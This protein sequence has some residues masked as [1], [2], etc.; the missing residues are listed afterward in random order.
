[1]VKQA[2]PRK[3][4]RPVLHSQLRFSLSDAGLLLPL[5]H[6]GARRRS[7]ALQRHAHFRGEKPSIKCRARLKTGGVPQWAAPEPSLRIDSQGTLVG[8]DEPTAKKN[9]CVCWISL[10][11]G[12][13]CTAETTSQKFFRPHYLLLGRGGVI[14]LLLNRFTVNPGEPASYFWTSSRADFQ[15]TCPVRQGARSKP[16]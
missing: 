15:R 16:G 11:G 9:D 10:A 1:V 13:F 3:W 2:F 6:S 7:H 4:D 8:V 14:V 5:W 12:A